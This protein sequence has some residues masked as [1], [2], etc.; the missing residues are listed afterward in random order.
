[1]IGLINKLKTSVKYCYFKT[2]PGLVMIALD[3][4]FPG[5]VK[6]EQIKT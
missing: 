2:S 1:M 3:L 5:P 6:V 4:G